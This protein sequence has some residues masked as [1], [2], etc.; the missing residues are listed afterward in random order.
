[1]PINAC[2][3]V[4]PAVSEARVNSQHYAVLRTVCQKIAEIETEGRVAIVVPADEAAVHKHK[5]VTEDSVE[6]DEDAS[7]PVVLRDLGFASIPADAGLRVAAPKRLVSMGAQL[8]VA[9]TTVVVLKRKFYRP[10]VGQVE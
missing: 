5:G 10:I 9:G 7:T 4:K 6:F 8:A 1:M 2:A 3:F